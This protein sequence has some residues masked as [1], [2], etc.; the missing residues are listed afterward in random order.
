MP[1]DHACCDDIIEAKADI[2]A[3]SQSSAQSRADA[4]VWRDA[5]VASNDAT[6]ERFGLSITEARASVTRLQDTID[7]R[8]AS[9][10]N[11]LS[12]RLP[13]WATFGGIAM[14]TVIGSLVTLV[15]MLSQHFIE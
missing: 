9:I 4:Q 13:P 5:H 10:E 6:F 14:G 15:V 1:T 2:R 11:K 12:N 8:L 3:M 7:A